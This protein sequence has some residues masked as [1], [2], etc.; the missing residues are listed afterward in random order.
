MTAIL[1]PVAANADEALAKPL[2]R[3][4]RARDAEGFAGEVEFCA[5]DVG[6][7]FPSREAALDAFAGRLEDDRPGRAVSLPPEE[8]YLT[9]RQVAVRQGGRIPVR[10]P[11][12][13]SFEN[14]R[15]WPAGGPGAVPVAWRLSISYWRI[16][17]PETAPGQARLAR[18]KAAG[19]LLSA[20]ALRAMAR[21]PLRPVKPQQP[22]DVG[23]FETQL[24]EDPNR[25]IADE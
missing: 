19:P 18:K 14:G 7:A 22:L 5:E 8:R 16:V 24:P 10:P 6:P 9:L 25:L 3:A 2:G 12:Q 11:V 13:P 15:R 17:Q 1:Y 23:L 20:Q 4:A 21:E